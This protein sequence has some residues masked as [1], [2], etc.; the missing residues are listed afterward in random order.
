MD[1]AHH[2]GSFERFVKDS[3]LFVEAK[4]GQKATATFGTLLQ[5]VQEFQKELKVDDATVNKESQDRLTICQ[6][7]L[8]ELQAHHVTH[9]EYTHLSGESLESLRADLK[10]ALDARQGLLSTAMTVAM[11]NDVLCLDFDQAA[12]PVLARVNDGME[13][14]MHIPVR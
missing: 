4:S 12:R 14:L 2:A 13:K 5:E 8:R 9:N 1:Y 7:D 3:C 6:R 11:E 10:A